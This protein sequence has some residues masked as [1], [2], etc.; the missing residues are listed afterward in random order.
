MSMYA[1]IASV[2]SII[3]TVG[4]ELRACP[5]PHGGGDCGAPAGTA[6]G[7]DGT[8]GDSLALAGTPC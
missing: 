5:C 7:H 3:T 2:I 4:I 8:P 6:G 1:V